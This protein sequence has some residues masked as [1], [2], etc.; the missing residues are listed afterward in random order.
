MG[1]LFDIALLLIIIISGA[2]CCKLGFFKTLKPFRKIIAFLVAWNFKSSSFVNMITDKILKAEAVKNAV[3]KWVD[4]SWG[5]KIHSA[6]EAPDVTVTERYDST[7]GIIGE[8]FDNIKEYCM[9]L[10]E[11]TFGGIPG[12]DQLGVQE[13]L[14]QFTDEVVTY[15]SNGVLNFVSAL[16]GFIILYALVSVG[17][18]LVI[19]LLDRLFKKGLFGL[20]NKLTGAIVGVGFGF[21]FAWLIALLFVNVLPMFFPIEK[22]LILSGSMGIVEWFCTK[23]MFSALFGITL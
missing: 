7:F 3:S 9:E 10:Y 13:K 19:K 5:D 6:T 12:S 21:V 16:L 15:I 22:E 4:N 17:F 18:I 2:A 20:V 11:K 8:I 1:N 23:F 14:E